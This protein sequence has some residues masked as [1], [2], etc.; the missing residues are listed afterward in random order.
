MKW[1]A[2]LAFSVSAFAAEK[3]VSTGGS[4]TTCSLASPCGL[5][6]GLTDANIADGDTVYLRAGTYTGGVSSDLAGSSMSHIAVVNYPGESVIIQSSTCTG[7]TP[8]LLFTGQYVDFGGNLTSHEFLQ[9]QLA[10]SCTNRTYQMGLFRTNGIELSAA[11]TH[12]VLRSLWIHDT[13]MGIVDSG[14]SNEY[15]DNLV[16]NTGFTNTISDKQNGHCIYPSVGATATL[17]KR[18]ICGPTYGFGYH[19]FNTDPNG[20]TFDRNI[21]MRCGLLSGTSVGPFSCIIISDSNGSNVRTNTATNNVFYSP[22]SFTGHSSFSDS[23]EF[24]GD[25]GGGTSGQGILV[26]T[27]NYAT[28]GV[29]TITY[30]GLDTVTSNANIEASN[31]FIAAA[32]TVVA[33]A[34][35]NTNTYRGDRTANLDFAANG[36]PATFT[37]WQAVGWEGASTWTA[38]LPTTNV[39]TVLSAVY[40]TGR[41]IISIVNWAA[42]NTAT[43]DISSVATAGKYVKIWDAQNL[44]AGP[45]WTGIYAGGNVTLATNGTPAV[46]NGG[47]G[48]AADNAFAAYL[49]TYVTTSFRRQSN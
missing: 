14:P 25:T 6:A 36:T 15:S 44:P 49:M 31:N 34:G 39:N 9:I 24:F 18:N 45:I 23:T 3:F 19:A 8:V 21:G 40:D 20:Y 26:H 22:V 42:A 29:P 13:G 37:T 28:G 47:T 32:T 35:L 11:A 12:I 16:Y 46:P 38:A 33:W 1:I 7:S 30:A 5:A 41:G 48:L 17:I 4:G 27:G 2:I 10:T 43:V